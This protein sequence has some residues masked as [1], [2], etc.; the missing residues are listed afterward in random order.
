MANAKLH[1]LNIL[2]ADDSLPSLMAVKAMLEKIGHSCTIVTDGMQAL[3]EAQQQP[4]DLLL[5]D[6]Q[7]PELLGSSVCKQLRNQSGLNQQSRII[8]LSGETRPEANIVMADAGFD[9]FLKKPVTKKALEAYLADALPSE[10]IPQT[11]TPQT[12]LLNLADLENLKKDLGVATAIKLLQLFDQELQVMINR[13][14]NA[15]SN[16]VSSEILAVAHILKNSAVL[17]GANLL[18]TEARSLNDQDG[19][20][21]DTILLEGRLLQLRCTQTQT[22]VCK[23]LETLTSD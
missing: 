10:T 13:L 21:V 23:Y 20:N 7:M 5:L 8:S 9:H 12:N 4:Y 19:N 15:L 11:N 6:E 2:I 14:E 22:A 3:K 16:K 17:Y 1:K 18:A